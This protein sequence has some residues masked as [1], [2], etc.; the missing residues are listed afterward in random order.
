MKRAK[1]PGT[2]PPDR[3]ARCS[4]ISWKDGPGAHVKPVCRTESRL[5]STTFLLRKCRPPFFKVSARADGG[6]NCPIRNLL[7]VPTAITSLPVRMK[8][9][10][11]GCGHRNEAPDKSSYLIYTYRGKIY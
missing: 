7:P 10:S 2:S 9:L 11:D 5:T 4:G 3:S 1:I 6:C 8:C